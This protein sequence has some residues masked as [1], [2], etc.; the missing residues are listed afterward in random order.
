MKTITQEEV[1]PEQKRTVT[2]Y[3]CEEPGCTFITKSPRD[4]NQHHGREHSFK[5]R[6]GFWSDE[7]LYFETEEGLKE[8]RSVWGTGYWSGPGWYRFWDD[9]DRYHLDTLGSY[10]ATL[11]QERDELNEKIDICRKLEGEKP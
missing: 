8:W 2:A 7:I 5:A 4:S 10:I 6:K 11:E 3:A 9:G 1:V